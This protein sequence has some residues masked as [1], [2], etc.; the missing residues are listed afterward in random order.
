M[1]TKLTGKVAWVT[2]GSSGIGRAIALALAGA[3]A[4]VVISARAAGALAEVVA[5]CPTGS[6]SALPLDV[7]DNDAVMAASQQVL[8]DH[9]RIDILV[10]AAGINTSKRN[11]ASIA[12]K[13]W[14]RIVQINLNGAFYCTAAVLPTMR[15]QRDGLVINVSSWAGRFVSQ[16]VGP[17]YSASKH[18]M[19]AMTMSL[20][21]EEC[22]HGI[23]A[24]AICPG[25]TA[26]PIMYNR[27]APPSPE[28][29]E[30]MLQ[31]EDVA[32]AA[33]FVAALPTRVCIN[34]LVVSPT[35]NRAFDSTRI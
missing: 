21:M 23:R 32:Q 18:A 3:G 24:C 28:V 27:P 2:G 14:E 5:A 30:K 12:P 13:E 35:W 4:T 9:G 11:W 29:L 10:N 1:M 22:I 25:E 15:A 8:A 17:A 34:E 7:A 16:L 33:L 20:N 26:T 31:P 6:V 19:T